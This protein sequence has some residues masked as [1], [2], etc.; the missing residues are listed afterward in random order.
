MTLLKL[1][2]ISKAYKDGES[3]LK[4]L[5]DVDLEL[6]NS[7][8]CIVMGP[9]G[10]GKTTLLNIA[11]TLDVPDEGSVIINNKELDCRDQK[12]AGMVKICRFLLRVMHTSGCDVG[13]GG[14]QRRVRNDG[15]AEVKIGGLDLQN[16]RFWHPR[17]V[18]S[19]TRG[20]GFFELRNPTTADAG[21][22]RCISRARRSTA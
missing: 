19:K 10:S 2:N 1:K 9:S 17:P 4:V 12:I 3:S 21:A 5:S 16:A 11:A 14:A 6:N 8:I 18:Q 15:P 20:D 22:P 13:V 7:E